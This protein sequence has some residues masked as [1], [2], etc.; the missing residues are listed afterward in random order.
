L[1][2]PIGFDKN[3]VVMRL[4]VFFPTCFSDEHAGI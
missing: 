3:P 2:R 1:W 4:T